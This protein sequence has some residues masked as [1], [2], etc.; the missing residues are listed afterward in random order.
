MK[1]NIL[2][3]LFTAFALIP[4]SKIDACTVSINKTSLRPPKI[5][6][7]I[8]FGREPNCNRMNGICKIISDPYGNKE[9]PYPSAGGF[10]S[11]E[12]GVLTIE[13][14]EN[15][16]GDQLIH[17]LVTFHLLPLDIALDLDGETL[18]N[19]RAPSNA[20]IQTGQYPISKIEGGYRILLSLK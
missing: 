7:Y 19:L 4:F 12:D 5:H 13:M 6:L 2:F 14:M 18:E 10:A 17:E 20:R 16:M 15:E 11:Y 1:K 9:F 3:I 8:D